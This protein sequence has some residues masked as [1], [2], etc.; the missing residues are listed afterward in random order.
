MKNAA[1]A[2]TILVLAVL[3]LIWGGMFGLSYAAQQRETRADSSPATPHPPTAT[4]SPTTGIGDSGTSGDRRGGSFLDRLRGAT[5]PDAS[6]RADADRWGLTPTPTS[7]PTRPISAASPGS[8]ATPSGRA[9]TSGGTSTSGG[10]GT[11]GSRSAGTSTSG[12]TRAERQSGATGGTGGSRSGEKAPA[13]GEIYTAPADSPAGRDAALGADAQGSGSVGTGGLQGLLDRLASHDI[14][15][16][17][18]GDP[19]GLTG[20]GA[21]ALIIVLLLLAAGTRRRH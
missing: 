12:G 9:P 7:A 14:R 8:G 10:G 19:A 6:P 17:G 11:A 13:P 21:A 16:D 20:R 1:L 4:S 3:A 5:Q 18:S 15:A 2:P